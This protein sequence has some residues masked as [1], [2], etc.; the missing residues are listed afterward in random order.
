MGQVAIARPSLPIR[1]SDEALAYIACLDQFRSKNLS[2][3]GALGAVLEDHCTELLLVWGEHDVTADP[4]AVIRILTEGRNGRDAHIIQGAGQWVQYER[5]D[6]VNRLL[7][8]WPGVN[9]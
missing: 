1:N 2:R 7:L 9:P 5:A 8:D 6:E 3:T 4:E